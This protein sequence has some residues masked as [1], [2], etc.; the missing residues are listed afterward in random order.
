MIGGVSNGT[1]MLQSIRTL[2]CC[3]YVKYL[4]PKKLS[5]LGRVRFGFGNFR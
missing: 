4:K 5:D 3:D 1:K 2:P